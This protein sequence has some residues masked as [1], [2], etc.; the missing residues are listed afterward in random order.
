MEL[1]Q[2]IQLTSDTLKLPTLDA[3]RSSTPLQGECER[4]T[5]PLDS[6]TDVPG[7]VT[8]QLVQDIEAEANADTEVDE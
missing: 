5:T 4:D 8:S 7:S 3:G 2:E 6:I 1:E